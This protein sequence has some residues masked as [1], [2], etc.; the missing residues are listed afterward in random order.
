MKNNTITGQHEKKKKKNMEEFSFE[1]HC[2]EETNKLRFQNFI[3]I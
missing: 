1:G 2:L 3:R